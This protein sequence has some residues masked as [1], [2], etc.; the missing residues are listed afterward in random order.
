MIETLEEKYEY[1]KSCGKVLKSYYFS[2]LSAEDQQAILEMCSHEEKCAIIFSAIYRA[3][4]EGRLGD[5]LDKIVEII[6]SPEN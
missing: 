5:K 2:T 6:N 4:E 3:E 1:L